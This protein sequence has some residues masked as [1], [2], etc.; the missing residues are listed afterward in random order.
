M[1]HTHYAHLPLPD[2]LKPC[3]DFH[4]HLC[5]GL[6]YGYLVAVE[7]LRLLGEDRSQDEELVAISENDA[8]SVDALQVLLG[9]TAGK[10]NL[11]ITNIG[12]N[13][14]T[15]F[16]RQAGKGFRF[17]RKSTYAYTGRDPEVFE[18]LE[19]KL[20]EG[21]ATADEKKQQK[22]MKTVDLLQKP[23]GEV[24]EITDAAI[25]E[26]AFAELAPSVACAVCGEL[27]MQTKMVRKG[28]TLLCRPCAEGV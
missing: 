24:F 25:P 9:T 11:T 22:L 13:V 28:D 21:T 20:A 27:T 19:K 6:V 8:C 18:A 16:S 1:N 3:I 23:V 10:G 26:P 5:P 7:S 2:T 14:Y 15:V 4:G 12:K 17:S